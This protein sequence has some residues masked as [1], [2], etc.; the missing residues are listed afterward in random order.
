M[1]TCNLSLEDQEI[2]SQFI[3]SVPGFSEFGTG[4]VAAISHM[5]HQELT[6]LREF[7]TQE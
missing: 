7:M 4:M 2:Q 6:C 1:E 3:E 5:T